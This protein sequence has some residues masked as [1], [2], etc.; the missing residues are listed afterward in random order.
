M[1]LI[2][3]AIAILAFLL[4]WGIGL[5]VDDPIALQVLGT[6][7]TISA[8]VLIATGIP[9]LIAGIGMLAHRAWGRILALILAVFKLFNIPFGTAVG[10]YAFWVLLQDDAELFFSTRNQA[11]PPIRSIEEV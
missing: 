4:L 2:S 7:G 9:S 6:I 10:V 5:V 3:L 1:S 8:C 11:E